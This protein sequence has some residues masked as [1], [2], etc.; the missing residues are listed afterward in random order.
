[1]VTVGLEFFVSEQCSWVWPILG[2]VY[3]LYL[4]KACNEYCMYARP[5]AWW[6]KW[7]YIGV[8]HTHGY[9]CKGY[10][11]NVHTGHALVVCLPV[12]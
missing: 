1:M 12:K 5:R 11:M 8:F 3:L 10:M 7:M 6:C 4:A 2:L 9:A